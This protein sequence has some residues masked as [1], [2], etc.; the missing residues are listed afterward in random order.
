MR[1]FVLLCALG[2]LAAT[3]GSPARARGLD[4]G[5]R[6]AVPGSSSGDLK[7]ACSS[8]AMCTSAGQS[9][10]DDSGITLGAD[11][12]FP[13][14]R[15]ARVGL[16]LLYTPDTQLEDDGKTLTLGSDL[17]VQGVA[18]YLSPLSPAVDLVLR[19]QVGLHAL[20]PGGDLGRGLDE[21]VSHCAASG[22]TVTRGNRYSLG[23]GF[24]PGLRIALDNVSLRADLIYQV[25][26]FALEDLTW[27]GGGYSTSS[28]PVGTQS[29]TY[30]GHR[31]MLH[32][33][34]E[35]GR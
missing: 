16:G 22:C 1:R 7:L 10:T 26:Q 6:L 35:F 12:L 9:L 24:G 32:L 33:G 2:T 17:L 13:V 3:A 27:A 5:L 34:V 23:Y 30:R 8:A 28:K 14:T 19:A 31:L 15:S 11:L 20:M 21:D 25:V 4:F 29:L 18:E